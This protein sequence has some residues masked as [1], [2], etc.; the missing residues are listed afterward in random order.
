M[1]PSLGHAWN[2][3]AP[4]ALQATNFLDSGPVLSFT[5]V[6][7]YNVRQGAMGRTLF[8]VVVS[9]ATLF[10]AYTS[11]GQDTLPYEF[12]GAYGYNPM[13]TLTLS[14]STMYGMSPRGGGN[15]GGVIFQVNTNG[16]GPSAL[17]QFPSFT[18]DG[19]YPN[20]SLTLSASTLYGMTYYGGTNNAGVIFKLNANGTG[21]ALLHEFVGNQYTGGPT[22]GGNPEGS[23]VVSGS[24]L[25][26]MTSVGGTNG[27][28]MVFQINTDGTGF[29]PLYQFAGTD[30]STPQGSLTLAGSVLYG[31]THSG[32]ANGYGVIFQISTNGTGFGLLHQFAYSDGAGPNRSLALSGSTLYG[33]TYEGGGND[34]GVIFEVNTNA[35]GYQV[36]HSFDYSDGMNPRGDLTLSGSTLYGMT[37]QGGASNLGVVFQINTGGT[38]FSLLHQF[39]GNPSDG[40]NPLGDVTASGSTL[41]G[42]TYAGGLY[43][44][45]V[46]FSLVVPPPPPVLQ[47]AGIAVQTNDIQI[48]WSASAGTTNIVQVTNGAADGSYSTNFADLSP[49]IFVVG[50]GVPT[51]NYLDAGGVTNTTTSSRYYRVRLVP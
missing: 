42:M 32:G 12:N 23:L 40:A 44:L 10:L 28:G 50:S 18:S 1:N 49:M 26:G 24:T 20:G 35:T 22:D 3:D 39:A 16:T 47:I 34:D 5:K 51:T 48:S 27:Y 8:V 43:N 4:T 45:G 41:Y 29:A 7:M 37:Y 14:G 19:Y 9:I 2:L 38:D 17:H 11:Q 13:A 46:I 6:H 21:Y 30:G 33:M 15:S 36:L 25:Y 31:T